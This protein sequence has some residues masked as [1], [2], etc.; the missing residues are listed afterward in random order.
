MVRTICGRE[1]G[2]GHN[3]LLFNKKG[4]LMGKTQLKGKTRAIHYLFKIK[5]IPGAYA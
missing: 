1:F 5:H 3:F 4:N 2:E